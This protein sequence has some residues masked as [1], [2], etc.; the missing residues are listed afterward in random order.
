MISVKKF[1][2]FF[3]TRRLKVVAHSEVKCSLFES[4]RVVPEVA[5]PKL[6]KSWPFQEI[7][8]LFSENL[9]FGCS[10]KR[11]DH[12]IFLFEDP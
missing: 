3:Y 5:N 10:S 8:Q 11:A 2:I 1:L 12:L 6:A 9:F 4:E 7:G